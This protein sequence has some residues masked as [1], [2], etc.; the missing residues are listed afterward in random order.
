MEEDE[1]IKEVVSILEKYALKNR[2]SFLELQL[3]PEYNKN[4]FIVRYTAE[5]RTDKKIK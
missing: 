5:L 4:E 2:L 1:S 3:F